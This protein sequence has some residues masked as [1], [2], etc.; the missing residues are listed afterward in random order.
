MKKNLFKS[1]FLILF[2]IGSL[3][4]PSMAAWDK[5]KP[6]GSR[7]LNQVDDDIRANNDAIESALD[8]DHDFTT[9]TTQT[10]KHEQVTFKAVLGTKPSLSA[11]EG[12][13]YTKSVS[14]KTQLFFEDEDGVESIISI[15]AG[16]IVPFCP[17]YFT[18][19]SN[20][21]FTFQWVT[22]NT[23]AAINTLLNPKGWYVCDGSALNLAASVYF[24]GAGRYL[25][26]I[27]DDRF[28]M[29]DTLCGTIGGA[30]SID[31][32]H[33][34]TTQSHALTISEMPSHT[35]GLTNVPSKYHAWN[36]ALGTDPT[37]FGFDNEQS[38][39]ATNSAGSGAAHSHGNTGTSLSATQEIRP[40]Y[41]GLVYIM[42]VM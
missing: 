2:L 26:N 41:L 24:N 13:L 39:T 3:A 34:H 16:I 15:P 6:A 1:L 14:G 22:A 5:T 28:I 4:S 37:H 17:G 40:L 30:N 18:N 19:G 35:H 32:S 31:F 7:S 23:I 10:G 38:V 9:G 8:Q 36:I 27:T 29:G 20:A 12:A 42:K 33:Y 25:P 21:G 11:D